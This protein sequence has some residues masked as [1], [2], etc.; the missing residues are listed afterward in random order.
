MQV[1]KIFDF[2]HDGIIDEKDL[3]FTF[4]SLGETNVS[5]EKIKNMISES[6]KPLDFDAFVG[7]FE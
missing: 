4:T 6:S 3:K 7:L 2:D 5:D 1:F